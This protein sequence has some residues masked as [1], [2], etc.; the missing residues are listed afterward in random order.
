[1]FLLIFSLIRLIFCVGKSVVAEVDSKR[2]RKSSIFHINCETILDSTSKSGRCLACTKHRKSLSTMA[3]RKQN[4]DRTHPSS[5]TTYSSLSTPE[6]D[7]RLHRIHHENVQLKSQIAR[8][9]EKINLAISKNSVL[10]DSEFDEDMRN[11]V[12]N[13]RD[14]VKR[15]F[16]EGSFQKLFWDE[17]E[18]AMS[19]KDSRSLLWHPVFIKW[20]F[21]IQHL[22]GQ[23]Y[24][25][26]R[27]SGCIH[28]PS[29][30]TLRDYTYYIPAKIG[31]S[32]AVAEQLVETIDLTQKANT[33]VSLVID[34]VHI[35]ENLVYDKHEGSL[36]G[37]ANL[38]D[39]NNHLLSFEEA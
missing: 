7:K 12:A 24:K 37:F 31:F 30:R 19:F 10:V 17:Q 2:L 26:L 22:S 5:H 15:S 13:C 35:K 8:L 34:E 16:S 36:I 6:K 18:K 39:T 14:D 38:G 9:K 28:L 4:D 11:M 20:C 33:C 29:Q 27:E 1:M 21:Y 3:S 25:L 23:S 32:P